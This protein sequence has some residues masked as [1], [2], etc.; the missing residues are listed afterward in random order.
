[1]VAGALI[2]ECAINDDKIRRLAYGKDLPGRSQ[3]DQDT[4]SASKQLFR[5]QDGEWRTNCASDDAGGFACKGKFVEF[6]VVAGP[7]G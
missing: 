5:G 2:A 3:T 4:T 6:S 1:M 7:R